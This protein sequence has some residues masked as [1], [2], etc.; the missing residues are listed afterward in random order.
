MIK[1]KNN[2]V[3]VCPLNWGL[4]HA[5]RCIPVIDE[6]IRKE[7]KVF[8]AGS[9]EVI[10]VIKQEFNDKVSYIHFDGTKINYGKNTLIS[11]ILFTPR[12]IYNSIKEHYKAKK[13]LRYTGAQFIISDN[14]YGLW[15]K[16]AKTAFITHQ[17]NIKLPPRL[18][19]FRKPLKFLIKYVVNKHNLLLIPDTIDKKTNLTGDL[20]NISENY[21]PKIYYCGI[22]SRFSNISLK[23]EEEKSKKGYVLCIVSGPEPQRSIFE[24]KLIKQLQTIPYSSFLLRGVP[25]GDNSHKKTGKTIVYNHVNKEK[26]SSLIEGASLIICRSGYSTLMDL[27]IFGKKALLIPTPGQPEQEYLANLFYKKNWCFYT[28]QKMLFLNK[29]IEK[30]I[31]FRGIPKKEK[32]NKKLKAA[33]T[34]LLGIRD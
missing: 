19:L 20:T 31:L 5:T 28:T 1:D 14:R 33:L 17:L 24:E 22:L 2:T 25:G 4:G 16:K 26:L 8:V 9:E 27:S 29:D 18:K 13:L 11:L 21:H 32:T 34:E 7:C 6:L 15:S 12:F 30:A 3:L 23:S 10:N